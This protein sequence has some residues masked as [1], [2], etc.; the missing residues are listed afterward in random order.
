VLVNLRTQNLVAKEAAIKTLTGAVDIGAGLTGYGGGGLL[1]T[2]EGYVQPGDINLN[3]SG[4][5]GSLG[6]NYLFQGVYDAYRSGG[7]TGGTMTSIFQRRIQV[8]RMGGLILI[9]GYL[10]SRQITSSDLNYRFT[11]AELG[12]DGQ[13]SGIHVVMNDSTSTYG[14]WSST[15][16]SDATYLT[17]TSTGQ[18]L[19]QAPVNYNHLKYLLD[20]TYIVS[21]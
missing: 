20:V 6:G 13:R 17:L 3:Y 18:T 5:A 21:T 1:I 14:T 12:L 7:Q 9:K 15:I 8:I 16:G 4:A 2:K 19:N 10:P 11:W